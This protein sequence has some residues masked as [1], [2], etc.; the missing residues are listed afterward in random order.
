MEQNKLLNM[1]FVDTSGSSSGSGLMGSSANKR[2]RETK[3]QQQ[4]GIDSVSSIS[5]ELCLLARVVSVVSVCLCLERRGYNTIKRL[6]KIR[7]LVIHLLLTNTCD[8]NLVTH[9]LVEHI[10]MV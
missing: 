9:H 2:K 7:R 4:Q 1:S 5:S 10:I 8:E 6:L 3:Q